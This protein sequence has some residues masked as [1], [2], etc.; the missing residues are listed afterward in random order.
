MVNLGALY[1][2]C[3]SAP[4]L[5]IS[6]AVESDK[7]LSP[8]RFL[9]ILL[10]SFLA[11]FGTAVKEHKDVGAGL[12]YT[13]HALCYLGGFLGLV[14]LP[15]GLKFTGTVI[16]FVIYLV[17]YA[18]VCLVR[19]SKKRGS[20]GAPEKVEKAQKPEKPKKQKNTQ[21]YTSLFSDKSED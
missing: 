16:I 1:F 11:A 8:D 14:L 3:I 5:I 13:V 17:L 6:L 2:T 4:L 19:A 12:G 21:Q 10:F 18:T 15:A 7:I 9:L 20:N